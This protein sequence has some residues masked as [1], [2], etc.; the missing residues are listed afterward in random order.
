MAAHRIFSLVTCGKVLYSLLSALLLS[1]MAHS[2][3][4]SCIVLFLFRLLGLVTAYAD[5]LPCEGICTDTHDP[6]LILRESDGTYFC[7]ATGGGL[8][9]HTAHSIQGPWTYD[10]VVLADGSSIDNPGSDDAWAPDVHE[11][12]GTYY[13]YYAVSSFGTQAS[14]IGLATSSSMDPGTWTDY[15]SIGLSSTDGDDYNT[16]HPNLFQ[17]SDTNYMTFGSF[18][19]DIFQTTMNAD[20]TMVSGD[21][22]YQIELNDTGTRPSEGS[23]VFEHGDYYYLFFSS[24]ICC[25]YDSTMPAPGEEYK[26]MV[27]RSDKIDGGYVCQ[28]LRSELSIVNANGDSRSTQMVHLVSITAAL[29]S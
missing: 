27:C 20:A 2:Y 18:W 13:C 3:F 6:S 22:P 17:T 29:R 23:Y 14:A 25:G 10:G 26:I 24:G 28:F 15:G 12:D 5:P 9:I 1:E 19:G 7:F 16:I 8:D 11:V 21:A 4:S